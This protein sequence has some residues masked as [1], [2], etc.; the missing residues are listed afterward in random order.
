MFI[1]HY[2]IEEILAGSEGVGRACPRASPAP[3][4]RPSAAW[5]GFRAPGRRFSGRRRRASGAPEDP[6]RVPAHA[7]DGQGVHRG[8]Q[9]AG[10]RGGCELSLA[11]DLR[12]MARGRRQVRPSRDDPRLL[13]RR[14]RDPTPCPDPR[15]RRARWRWSSRLGRSARRRR[16]SSASSTAWCPTP[17]SPRPRARPLSEWRAARR[18]PWPRPSARSSTAGAKPMPDGLAE[19]RRWFMATV[20]QPAARRAMRA[21]AERLRAAGPRSPTPRS[22]RSGRTGPRSTW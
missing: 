8:D 4:F 17:S 19:E 1:T 18:S 16:T 6:R 14:R 15:T 12:Y 2:D 3:P 5:R 21:Y 10:A 7:A 22:G 20:S 11:C 9:R 13:P